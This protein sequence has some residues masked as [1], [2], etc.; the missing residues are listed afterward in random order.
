MRVVEFIMNYTRPAGNL[1]R[2][3]THKGRDS[4]GASATRPARDHGQGLL[5][6]MK[7]KGPLHLW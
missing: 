7:L 1:N 4:N 2:Q 6:Q 3:Y 5:G